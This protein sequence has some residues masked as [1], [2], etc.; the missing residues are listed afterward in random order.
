[1][2]VIVSL[3]GA[4]KLRETIKNLKNMFPEE[5]RAMVLEVAYVDILTKAIDKESNIPVDTGRLRSSYHVKYM[6]KPNPETSRTKAKLAK[7][8]KLPESQMNYNYTAKN[9]DEEGESVKTFDGTL[10]ESVDLDSV[11]V[12]TNVEYAKKINREGGGGPNSRSGKPKGTGQGHFDK[13]VAFGKIGLQK[14]MTNLAK[15]LEGEISRRAAEKAKDG[16]L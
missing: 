14:E 15:R 11:I 16:D 2:S 9:D 13:A 7:I 12:G 8:G 3:Q 4:Y 1:M 6:K 5:V 10:S